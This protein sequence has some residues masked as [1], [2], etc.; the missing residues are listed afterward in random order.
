[1]LIKI[2]YGSFSASFGQSEHF[3]KRIITL[4][5]RGINCA[6][7]VGEIASICPNVEELDLAKNDLSD[8]QEVRNN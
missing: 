3:E 5:G 6:G 1:L 2:I 4:D 7:A 8:F